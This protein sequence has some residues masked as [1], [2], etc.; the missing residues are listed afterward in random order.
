MGHRTKAGRHAIAVFELGQ[1]RTAHPGWPRVDAA[2]KE[3]L[4]DGS[5]DDD[6]FAGWMSADEVIDVL[7]LELDDEEFWQLP[8][9]PSSVRH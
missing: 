3:P 8:L 2:P 6:R 1:A 9:P 4:P 5:F 7:M